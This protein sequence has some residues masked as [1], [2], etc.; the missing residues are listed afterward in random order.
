MS[1][2]NM[3]RMREALR[4]WNAGDL[5]GYLAVTDPSI[6]FYTSG[7]FPSHDSVYRGPD[8]FR[9]FWEVFHDPWDSLEID[10]ERLDDVDE[11]V[12]ALMSFRAVGRES[13]V[14]VRMKFAN[15][16]TFANGLMVELRAYSDWEQGLE[17]VGLRD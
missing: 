17:A 1:Q 16:A 4:A 10:T 8:G 7:V 12:V 14:E 2:E 5:A 11:R 13:G 15:V 3:D 9:K 6:A